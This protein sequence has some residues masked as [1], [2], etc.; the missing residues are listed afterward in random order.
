MKRPTALEAAAY[1]EEIGY[2]ELSGGYEFDGDEFIDK[3]EACGWVLKNG[4]PMKNW[5]AVV[6]NWARWADGR[7]DYLGKK[8][9]KTI[10]QKRKD[11]N[12]QDGNRQ[13]L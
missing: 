10:S 5:R 13:L 1:A 7:Y 11:Y 4:N 2:K 3:Y 9:K 6:R 12:E 8:K